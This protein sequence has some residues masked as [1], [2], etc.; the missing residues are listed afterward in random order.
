MV[1]QIKTL[2][3][4]SLA[5][6]LW[7][8]AQAAVAAPHP[9]PAMPL[10]ATALPPAGYLDF[11]RRRAWDC[12]ASQQEVRADVVKIEAIMAGNAPA[13]QVALAATQP[14][15]LSPALAATPA[16]TD[17]E[18]ALLTAAVETL[19]APPGDPSAPEMTRELW[20]AIKRANDQV[21]RAFRQSTD[22]A[23][24]GKVDYWATPI[25]DGVGSGDCEDF[26]LEKQRAL[27]AAGV[28]RQALN[29]A[30]VTT[31]AGEIH[32]VLLVATSQ[33]EFVLDNLTPWIDP[34][35]KTGYHFIQREVGGEA[36]KWV[37]VQDPATAYV[38][39][40]PPASPPIAAFQVASLH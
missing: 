12:G 38:P 5:A 3:R 36:F 40:A 6:G 4:L 30:V 14:A 17:G 21:N 15:A 10:G 34:W 22:I 31:R 37:M 9:A 35:N 13:T 39:P 1:L 20:S 18:P 29:I 7:F 2:A 8:T 24:Y 11:C 16:P 32:A 33:G 23:T 27:L 25:E 28:P 26:V 19:A